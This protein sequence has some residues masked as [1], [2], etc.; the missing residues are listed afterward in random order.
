MTQ[1]LSCRLK[2]EMKP[3][4]KNNS[5]DIII[6]QFQV[7]D[8]LTLEVKGPRNEGGRHFRVTSFQKHSENKEQLVSQCI[9]S[10]SSM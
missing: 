7:F 9:G 1:R 3:F 5:V 6:Q 4:K 2:S 8:S 10:A